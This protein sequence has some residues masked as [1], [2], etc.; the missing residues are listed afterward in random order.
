MQNSGSHSFKGTENQKDTFWSGL[1]ETNRHLAIWF[2]RSYVVLL[3]TSPGHFYKLYEIVL[4][5][6]HFF[7]MM[8]LR[9]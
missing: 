4:I 2:V 7:L 9:Q 5:K 3:R 6:A 1:W 8:F